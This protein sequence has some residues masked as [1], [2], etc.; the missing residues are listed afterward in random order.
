M[1]RS[2]TIYRVSTQDVRASVRAK[3]VV[4]ARVS[5][6]NCASGGSKA[7]CA[8]GGSKANCASG[9]NEANGKRHRGASRGALGTY[10]RMRFQYCLLYSGPQVERERVWR[11]AVRASPRATRGSVRIWSEV[12]PYNKYLSIKTCIK[13]S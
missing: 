9:G 5:K 2:D 4:R 1:E 8:S 11:I 7:K 3:R 6:A 13:I 12:T 10:Y